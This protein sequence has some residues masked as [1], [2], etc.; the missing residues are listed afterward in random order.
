MI[1]GE[2]F[3]SLFHKGFIK[4]FIFFQK[5]KYIRY[6]IYNINRKSHILSISYVFKIWKFE[7]FFQMNFN[8]G[9]KPF[10]IWIYL[11]V[12]FYDGW[13]EIILHSIEKLIPDWC[14]D[15]FVNFGTIRQLIKWIE[16]RFE[17]KL[18]IE[19]SDNLLKPLK[20]Y[21]RLAL[22]RSLLFLYTA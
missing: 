12:K 19:S 8:I 1:Y 4:S 22:L 13:N 9:G 10:C 7:A 21:M 6:F 18:Y 15:L 11:W 14:T 16:N 2:I 3:Y 17:W 5:K 20:S